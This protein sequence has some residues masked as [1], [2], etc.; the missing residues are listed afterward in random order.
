MRTPTKPAPEAVTQQVLAL[1][2]R[3][4]A[5]RIRR[6]LR[7]EDLASRAD[8]SAKTLQSIERGELGTSIGAHMKVLWALGLSAEVDL[9]ADPGLDQTGLTLEISAQGKRVRVKKAVDNDF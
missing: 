6:K 8:I 9:I 5:A 4:R 1:A 3:I 7:V 2:G